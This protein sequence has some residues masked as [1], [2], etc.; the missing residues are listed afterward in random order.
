MSKGE[1]GCGWQLI[2]YLS[3][4]VTVLTMGRMSSSE[5]LIT[6]WVTHPGLGNKQ[7]IALAMPD[8]AWILQIYMHLSLSR[9]ISI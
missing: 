4:C 9:P 7:G 3:I 6:S 8:S 2:R 5:Q 1:G